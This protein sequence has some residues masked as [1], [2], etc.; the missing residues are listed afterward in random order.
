M[1]TLRNVAI[2]L[3]RLNGITEIK[4]T[5]EWVGRDRTRALPLLA[6]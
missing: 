1:A 3:L 4:R 5:I 2:G 6:T